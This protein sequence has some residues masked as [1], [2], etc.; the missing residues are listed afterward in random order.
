MLLRHYLLALPLLLTSGWSVVQAA[1]PKPNIV[2]IIA[3]DLGGNALAVVWLGRRLNAVRLARRPPRINLPGALIVTVPSEGPTSRE[4]PAERP[5]Q[6][7]AAGSCGPTGAGGWGVSGN[8]ARIIS[9]VPHR[10]D[11]GM[12]PQ[13]RNSAASSDA[14]KGPLRRSA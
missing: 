12:I 2:F 13:I 1:D 4:V 14:A 6:W 11:A 10:Y 3:D 9:G 5:R 8:Q 7:R